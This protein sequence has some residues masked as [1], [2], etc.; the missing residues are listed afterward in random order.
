M[1]DV[2]ELETNWELHVARPD[3]VLY[4]EVVEVDVVSKLHDD[5]RVLS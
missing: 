3:D 5:F 4:F 1:F 2:K